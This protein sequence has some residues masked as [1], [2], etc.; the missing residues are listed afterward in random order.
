GAGWRVLPEVPGPEGPLPEADVQP[1]ARL[2]RAVGRV[3][4]EAA[5]KR[6]DLER[7]RKARRTSR[8]SLRRRA[9]PEGWPI[10][11][12]DELV[13]GGGGHPQ[14]PEVGE[15]SRAQPQRDRARGLSPRL[16]VVH[17]QRRLGLVVHEEAGRVA[18]HLDP[19]LR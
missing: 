11:S 8:M 16:D 19:D 7:G 5:V 9:W 6:G 1:G 4:A 10:F 18:P 17:D 3:R 2:A 15:G 12:R 13:R 14:V